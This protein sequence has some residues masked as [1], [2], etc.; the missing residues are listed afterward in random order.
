MGKCQNKICEIGDW[1]RRLRHCYIEKLKSR[2]L[3]KEKIKS[4]SIILYCEHLCKN[5]IL[6][7]TI[8]DFRYLYKEGER[9]I[10][11][12]YH[13]TGVTTGRLLIYPQPFLI[14]NDKLAKNDEKK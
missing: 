1:Y 11:T 13:A 9:L 14:I 2:E 3:P 10:S 5:C 4:L 6:N 12:K 7:K 8:Q